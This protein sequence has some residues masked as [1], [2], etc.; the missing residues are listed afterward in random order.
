M[1]HQTLVLFILKKH[2]QPYAASN[3]GIVDIIMFNCG[4]FQVQTELFARGTV[5]TSYIH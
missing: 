2:F 4:T 1:L 5:Q 3:T